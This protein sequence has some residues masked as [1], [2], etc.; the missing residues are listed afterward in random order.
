MP[1]PQPSDGFEWT[2]APWG[3]VLRCRPLQRLAPHFFTAASLQLRNDPGEWNEVAAFAGV[4]AEALQ[5]LTQVHGR[6]IAVVESGFGARPRP[7]AD[8][9]ITNAPSAALVVR[10]A[11]CAPIL[12][13]DRRIGVTAAVHAGWRSTMQRIAPAVV[14]ALADT[15][16]SR[17]EDLVAAI[18]PSLGACCGEM[19]DEV[20]DTFREAGHDEP[21]LTRWFV[22]EPGR[23]PHFDLWR[24]NGD[25]LERAGVSPGSIHVSGLCTR[26]HPDVFHSYRARG[27][28]VG[29]MAAVIRANP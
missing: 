25:Q 5:L 9:A 19:G 26:S 2:Q 6:R 20:V 11:D 22:R 3:S 28:A 13:A 27:Q 23:R 16:G 17:P 21:S 24:A 4:P 7:E 15:Y 1:V 18:G 8:A 29:R 14:T 10:V 12:I